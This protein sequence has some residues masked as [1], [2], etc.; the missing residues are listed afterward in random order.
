MIMEQTRLVAQC[1]AGDRQAMERL[2]HDYQAV[3]FRLAVSI[4]D[5]PQDAEE[6]TQ[7]ALLTALR[8]LDDFRGEATLNTW[9]YAITVNL[10][11]N[12]LRSRRR[13]AAMQA[14]FQTW[15]HQ[16]QEASPMIE[17]TV[18]ENESNHR[19]LQAVRDLDEKHRLPVILR[20]YHDCSIDEIAQILDI[21]PGTVH[22]RLNK[23]RQRL[24]AELLE[25]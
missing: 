15:Q 21:P 25:E 11:R 4:L 19:V 22:S 20:Y 10:C 14:V 13:R 9:L 7:D 1:R 8:A 23:A 12:R 24:K 2:V 6:A 16:K 3:L 18:L 5:D 17:P